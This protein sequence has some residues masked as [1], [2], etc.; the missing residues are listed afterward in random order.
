MG[1]SSEDTLRNRVAVVTEA[2]GQEPQGLWP[3]V[4]GE[5][6]LQAPGALCGQGIRAVLRAHWESAGGP[7]EVLPPH[8]REEHPCEARDVSSGCLR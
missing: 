2:S 6:A 7:S 4:A 5:P 1:N 3:P 8:R